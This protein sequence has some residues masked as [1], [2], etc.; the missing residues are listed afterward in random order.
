MSLPGASSSSSTLSG[1]SS[2]PSSS[3]RWVYDVFLSFRREDTRNNFIAHLY[4]ALCE[5]GINT[6]IDDDLR[7]GEEI[8]P[9]LL[10]AIEGSSISIIVF[11]KNYAS[12]R[13]CLDELLKIL[14]WRET[15]QQMVVPV[16][17]NVDPSEVRN[18]TGCVK[19]ALAELEARYND[20]GK[21]Q[22]WRAALKVVANL[23]GWHL[24][25]RNESKFIQEIIQGLYPRIISQACLYVAKNP[26]GIQSRVE[27]VNSLLHI[28]KNDRRMVGIYGRGGIGKTTIAK[29]IFNLI[30]SQFEARSFLPM[31][32][33]VP[34]KK[35]VS[36]ICKINFLKMS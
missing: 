16:F 8:S 14:E 1:S 15:K 4:Y 2:T 32:E 3:N 25:K 30:G 13:W 28:G 12:T 36:S 23:S 7:N 26:V 33:K 20:D 21:L 11:S 10:K 27:H 9:T 34:K 24:Q 6:Y 22:R 17:Y 19:D 18:Q 5:K 31:L 35:M 29:V